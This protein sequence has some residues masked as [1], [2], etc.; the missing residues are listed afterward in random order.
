VHMRLIVPV[1]VALAG[2]AAANLV[3]DKLIK[4]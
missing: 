2:A 1:L 3:R 4:H